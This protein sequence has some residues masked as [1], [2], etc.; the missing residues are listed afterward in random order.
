MI[1]IYI[2]IY[3]LYIYMGYMET[4]VYSSKSLLRTAGFTVHYFA[5]WKLLALSS[6]IQWICRREHE[7]QWLW[8]IGELCFCLA[9][10]LLIALFGSNFNMTLTYILVNMYIYIRLLIWDCSDAVEWQ[11]SQD[12]VRW[13]T[14]SFVNSAMCAFPTL[15]S[16]SLNQ[17]WNSFWRLTLGDCCDWKSPVF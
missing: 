3:G 8:L 7:A 2:F 4:I 1:Y 16:T 15:Q 12:P 17:L 14:D 11:C 10:S 13:W 5:F 6:L 9:V